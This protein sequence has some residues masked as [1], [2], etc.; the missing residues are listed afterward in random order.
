M[1]AAERHF[2]PWSRNVIEKVLSD[3]VQTGDACSG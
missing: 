2:K 3:A 1:P